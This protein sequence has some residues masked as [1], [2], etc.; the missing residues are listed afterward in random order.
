MSNKQRCVDIE[1]VDNSA[2]TFTDIYDVVDTASLVSVAVT[3]TE[4]V[5]YPIHNIRRIRIYEKT[6]IVK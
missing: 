3:R 5:S 1:F 2:E 4:I 6:N